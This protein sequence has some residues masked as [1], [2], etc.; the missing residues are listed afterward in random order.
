MSAQETS[1]TQDFYD[2]LRRNLEESTGTRFVR[3]AP[4]GNECHVGSANGVGTAPNDEP[5][6]PA[7]T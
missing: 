2:E 1:S 3:Q 4:V 6:A 7:R 5:A